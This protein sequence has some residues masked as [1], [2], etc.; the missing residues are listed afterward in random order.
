MSAKVAKLAELELQFIPARHKMG[1]LSIQ[2]DQSDEKDIF[3]NNMIS[4]DFQEFLTF[5]G[6]TIDLLGWRDHNGGLDVSKEKRTGEKS[7][8]VPDEDNRGPIM[9]HVGPMIPEQPSDPTRKR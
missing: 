2:K 4:D 8:F 9:F 6:D 1:I 7:I 3:A 5:L